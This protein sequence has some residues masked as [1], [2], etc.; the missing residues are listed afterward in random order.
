MKPGARV[1]FGDGLL[2]GKG[3]EVVEEGKPSD[4]F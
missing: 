3:S 2:K 1:S 4:P